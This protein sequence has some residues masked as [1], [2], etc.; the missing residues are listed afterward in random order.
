MW[1]K[2]CKDYNIESRKTSKMDKIIRCITSD[3]SV[4]ASAIDSSDMVFTAQKL[5]NM[6]KTSISAL[7][8][9]LTGA[10]MMGAQLKS[11][12]SAIT[13]TV[14]GDGPIGT[15]VARADNKGNVRGYVSNPN[16]DIPIREID[17][18]IDVGKAVG[19]TGRL[20]VIRDEGKGEPY[21]G[22][23]ELISGEIAEDLT[24]YF[25]TSEQIPTFCAL[26]VLVNKNSGAVMLS[27]G[28]LIQ[29][30]PGAD[31][32]VINSLEA[33]I[34]NLE[35]VTTMLA[36]G[37]SPIKMCT[38]ALDGFEIEILDEIEVKYSCNCNKKRFSEL[39]LTLEPNEIRELPLDENGYAETTCQYCSRKYYFSK[40]ELEMIAESDEKS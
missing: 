26:G 5:H 18:K 23:V 12:N 39:L 37:L 33:N 29:V 4:M 19:H 20:T 32:N 22:H 27:G 6:T 7:G 1:Q 36:K 11:E 24:N 38:I 21:I 28:L 30:L 10:S 31:D 34:S 14:N 16:V 17:S 25:A 3:G 40:K 13:V 9:L 8:R 2:R 15:L 35:S